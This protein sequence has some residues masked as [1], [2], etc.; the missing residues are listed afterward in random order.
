MSQY[1]SYRLEFL[2]GK[3]I[4]RWAD[5]SEGKPSRGLTWCPVGQVFSI[6]SQISPSSLSKNFSVRFKLTSTDLLTA[7]SLTWLFTGIAYN[8]DRSVITGMEEVS[9]SFDRIHCVKSR[10]LRTFP[11]T[12]SILVSNRSYVEDSLVILFHKHVYC[13]DFIVKR[14]WRSPNK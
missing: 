14:W 2:R 8:C 9:S 6:P 7:S 1:P 13:D 11:W 4:M 12:C 5:E 10:T 3:S